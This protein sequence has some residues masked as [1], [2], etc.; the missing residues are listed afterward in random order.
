MER[1]SAVI[2]LILILTG[3]SPAK[4]QRTR[5][6]GWGQPLP[7]GELGVQHHAH[8]GHATTVEEMDP[9]VSMFEV[10]GQVAPSINYI[11]V[12]FELNVLDI[13]QRLD[14]L[15]QNYYTLTGLQNEYAC[16]AKQGTCNHLQ[17]LG[18]ALGI[19]TQN[20][21]QRMEKYQ[22]MVPQTP[23]RQPRQILEI[24][25]VVFAL[26]TFIS[27]FFAHEISQAVNP[28]AEM[29]KIKQA[30]QSMQHNQL[31]MLDD[32]DQQMQYT[33][34]MAREEAYEHPARVNLAF[35]T[36]VAQMERIVSDFERVMDALMGHR[37]SPALITAK[38]IQEAFQRIQDKANSMH[39]QLLIEYPSHLFQLETTFVRVG[40]DYKI[41]LHVPCVANG[42][43]MTLYRYH[44]MPI[45]LPTKQSPK[46]DS[47][48][49]L[50]T[51]ALM[52][53]QSQGFEVPTQKADQRKVLEVTPESEMFATNTDNQVIMFSQADLH[54]CDKRHSILVCDKHHVRR[55][56]FDETCLGAMFSRNQ[57]GARRHCEIKQT[58]TRER[59]WATSADEFMVYPRVEGQYQVTCKNQSTTPNHRIRVR[60]LSKITV[61]MGCNIQLETHAIDT[62][63]DI[64]SFATPVQEPWSWNPTTANY[65]DIPALLSEGGTHAFASNAEQ[66]IHDL[67]NQWQ[68]LAET[69]QQEKASLQQ[70]TMAITKL[71][72]SYKDLRKQIED[73]TREAKVQAPI[74]E[75]HPS[76]WGWSL[77][78]TISITAIAGLAFYLWCK[79]RT[80]R[81]VYTTNA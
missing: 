1:Y 4:S 21:R 70:Q 41:M 71:E 63:I 64:R 42:G 72:E 44:P 59:V 79:Q 13:K 22:N 16:W 51:P 65:H 80:R 37:L 30:G 76:T 68:Q 75:S 46:F 20:W 77:T 62:N 25:L 52:K 9:T 50:S 12:E 34:K 38:G 18:D 8:T 74:W 61:P 60:R 73:I 32:L 33:I 43:L 36:V 10:I 67:D 58:Y 39:Y 78:A 5:G 49:L 53:L 48:A 19:H 56:D 2:V 28:N 57:V 27:S 15:S 40:H 14:K 29:S 11:H 66:T 81:P 3:P 17:Q 47:L 23:D 55:T 7:V 35:S 6:S 69:T 26:G 54:M 24:G 31:T 45:P